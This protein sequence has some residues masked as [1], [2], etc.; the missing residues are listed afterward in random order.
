MLSDKELLKTT[1]K[2]LKEKPEVFEALLEFERT[3][4]LPKLNYKERANFTIDSELLRRIESGEGCAVDQSVRGQPLKAESCTEF[5][6]KNPTYRAAEIFGADAKCVILKTKD[7][8][9]K[10][11][12]EV[13][14]IGNLVS[15]SEKLYE[16]KHITIQGALSGKTWYAVKRDEFN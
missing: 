10:L 5:A 12:D 1:E 6:R 16:I 2:L 15:D 11:I 8:D 9:G 3:G 4:K 7:R 13:Y 14:T